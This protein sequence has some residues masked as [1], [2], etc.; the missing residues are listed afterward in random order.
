MNK[1]DKD[2]LRKLYQEGNLV[3]LIGAGCSIPFGL[4]SWR[5]LIEH[6][7]D[8]FVEENLK[9]AI[10]KSLENN[11]YLRAINDILYFGGISEQKINEIVVEEIEKID[12]D[13][14]KDNNLKDLANMN[15]K[16][17]LTMN[18]DNFMNNF[19]ENSH[20]PVSLSEIDVDSYRLLN[21][22][23]KQVLHLHGNV[24][25]EGTIIFSDKSY[26]ELYEQ[27]KY[28]KLFKLIGAAKRFLIVGAS[29]DDIFISRLIK[30]NAD[31]FRNKAYILINSTEKSKFKKFREEYNLTI[32]EY[33]ASQHGKNHVKAIRGIL[34]EI[35]NVEEVVNEEKLTTEEIIGVA[36]N[37]SRAQEIEEN[38]FHKKLRLEN[39]KPS[40]IDLSKN[41]FMAAEEYINKM[42]KQ[43][44]ASETIKMILNIVFIKYKEQLVDEYEENG[45]S[46][47][48]VKQVHKCLKDEDFTRYMIGVEKHKIINEY[49]KQG[50][51]HNLADDPKQ[52]VWWGDLRF[53]KKKGEE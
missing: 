14:N 12:F 50:L 18:Y 49:E 25:N 44:F 10:E 8:Q 17:Y 51:I 35:K 23:K 37:S 30:E 41:Y 6:I 27:E 28:T 46:E 36:I 13:K 31:V 26:R 9:P 43:G 19:L 38:L 11:D 2:E 20:I 48:F 32:L 52:E 7:S 16:I 1:R 21:R 42:K 4:P 5:K 24:S 45:N 22:D 53:I 33:D 40:I 34:N 29:F 47:A 3:P 39:I 15:F